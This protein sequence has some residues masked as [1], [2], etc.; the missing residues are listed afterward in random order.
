MKW[1]DE[2][3][4]KN[5]M[6]IID[7]NIA[8]QTRGIFRKSGGGSEW[9][10]IPAEEG[11]K[12]VLTD[13]EIFEL[14]ELV[15]KIEQHYGFPVDVEWAR[16]A[17]GRFYIVQSRPIT[18]LKNT[19]D[20]VALASKNSGIN[21]AF[22]EEGDWEIDWD[23]H[24][25]HLAISFTCRYMFGPMQSEFDYSFKGLFLTFKEGLVLAYVN[26]EEL[27]EF[28]ES[29]LNRID[30]VDK[31]KAW[32]GTF[33]NVTDRVV[34]EL[35]FATS[36]RVIENPEYYI[37]LFNDYGVWQFATKA[38]YGALPA[39][40]DE[41]IPVIIED[42]RKYSEK[43][44][45]NMSIFLDLIDFIVGQS[46]GYSREQVSALLEGE[47]VEYAKTGNLPDKE[48]LQ[49]R[50]KESGLFVDGENEIFVDRNKKN[51][52]LAKWEPDFDGA[53]LHGI[54][55]FKGVVRGRCKLVVGFDSSTRIEEGDILV[56]TMTDPR[57]V[58]IM[59]KS[60]AF[61]TDG[62]GMLCHA[63]IVARELKKPC[64]I[65][66]KIATQVLHDGDLVEVDAEKGVVTVLA[67]ADS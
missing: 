53:V 52:I 23:A 58:P 38:V 13:E 22:L 27:S 49:L 17:E 57:F 63:A 6:K 4:H 2:A 35:E 30:T 60:A 26:P 5:S 34:G 18:T 25:S 47:L 59:K 32:S 39:E 10:D 40:I 48:I 29:L 36:D 28:S 67:R 54:T 51:A 43:F 14:S 9:R 20:D 61:V 24:L 46:D 64:I 33:K 12:Q 44:Y 55:A 50:Y 45:K 37:N 16:D 42:A 1:S 19:G 41:Q 56:T 66:T 7:K 11:S 21:L 62:G 65:G 3:I 8:E 15:V 31:A